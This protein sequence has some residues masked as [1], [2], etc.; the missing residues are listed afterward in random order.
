[1][2]EGRDDAFID[3]ATANEYRSMI[4]HGLNMLPTF[5]LQFDRRQA[6]IVVQESAEID[7]LLAAGMKG[8]LPVLG[9][10][11]QITMLANERTV[12]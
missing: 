5:Y 10:N 11:I 6:K 12:A 3:R 2:F 8:P 9:G 4:E 1:M 7:R